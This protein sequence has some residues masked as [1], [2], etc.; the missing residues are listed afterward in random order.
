MRVGTLSSI[1]MGI[2]I[3]ML[4]VTADAANYKNWIPVVPETIDGCAKS[5][6]P[7]GVN[8]ESGGEAWSS[9]QQEYAD[10]DKK[11]ITLTIVSGASPHIQQFKQMSMV[12]AENETQVIQSV[13]VSGHDG[14]VQL[15]KK[16]DSGVLYT[17]V[18][19][20]TLVAIQAEPA[21]SQD[22]LL[23]L[24]DEVPLEE[25]AAEAE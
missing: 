18:G 22:K 9:L 2:G 12:Q 14:I 21:T 20:K 16:E 15:K 19:E 25:I 5:G 10:E 17:M 24:A 6:E 3:L 11:E 8:M 23:S 13:D 4:A 7:K 1:F